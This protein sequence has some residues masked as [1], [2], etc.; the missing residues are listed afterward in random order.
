MITTVIQ[1]NN[2]IYK[3]KLKKHNNKVLIVIERWIE[4]KEQRTLEYY[5]DYRLQSMNLD[6]TTRH[7]KCT[8][9]EW[10]QD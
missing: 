1:I 4:Q 3:W 10:F 6:I 5:K 2:R 9:K 8:S 7:L